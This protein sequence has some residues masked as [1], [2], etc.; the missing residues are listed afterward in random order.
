[1]V[2]HSRGK[3]AAIFNSTERQI[4]RKGAKIAKADA[5]K[6]RSSATENTTEDTEK[7]IEPRI[8]RITRIRN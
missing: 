2:L 1:V 8:A 5:K 3:S 7:E 4:S 6:R